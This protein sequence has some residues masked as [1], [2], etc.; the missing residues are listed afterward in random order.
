[1]T[2]QILAALSSKTLD[3]FKSAWGSSPSERSVSDSIFVTYLK[4]LRR[5]LLITSDSS[6]ELLTTTQ[7]LWFL[8]GVAHKLFSTHILQH[9]IDSVSTAGLFQQDTDQW[10]V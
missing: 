1:M 3:D 9:S 5:P 10:S 6:T 7:Y 4:I 8:C 2:R